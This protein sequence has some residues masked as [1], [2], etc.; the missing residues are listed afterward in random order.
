MEPE[1][2]TENHSFLPVTGEASGLAPILLLGYS[3]V[4]SLS[5]SSTLAV[6]APSQAL[7]APRLMRYVS[8]HPE[9]RG[10]VCYGL[11]VEKADGV[12]SRV[13]SLSHIDPALCSP[14]QSGDGATRVEIV[15]RAL[16]AAETA[17]LAVEAG[18]TPPVKPAMR[19]G[20]SW[21]CHCP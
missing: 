16:A 9:T 11:V 18:E 7:D 19:G 17:W 15:R 12:P 20:T 2:E 5:V 1:Y 14:L 8:H 21:A 6:A 13:L 3:Y 10:E 4:P